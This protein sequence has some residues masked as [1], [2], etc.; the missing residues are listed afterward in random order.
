MSLRKITALS[1]I[2]SLSQEDL[3]LVV[4]DPTGTA[5]NKKITARNLFGNVTCVSTSISGIDAA[6]F[7]LVANNSHGSTQITAGK[8]LVV[9]NQSVTGNDQ[10]AIVGKSQLVGSGSNVTHTHAVARLTL[11]VGNAAAL[12]V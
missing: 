1:E 10:F 6:K 2:I 11:D 8:F 4:D 12:S 7:T 9:K 5:I 3:L